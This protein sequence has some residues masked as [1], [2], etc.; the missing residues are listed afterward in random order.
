[1]YIEQRMNILQAIDDPLLFA[2]WFRNRASW[3]SWIVFLQALFALQVEDEA[4]FASCT[5][6]RPLPTRQSREAFLVVGRRGGKS[7]ICALIGVYLACFRI[8]RLSPGEKGI[9]MLLAAD[10]RQARVLI[11]YVKAFLEGVPMLRAM[12][13]NETA[14]AISL[15]NQVAIEIHTA[16]FR[17]VRG[18]TICAAIC[19]EI[20]Y[21]RSDESAN[22]DSEILNA[23]RPA[24]ATIPNSMLLCLSTPYSR[25]GALWD[26]HRKHFGKA[27]DVLVWQ[28]PTLT[29]NSSVPAS[30]I[31]DALEEDPASAS[32]EYLAQFRSDL[33]AFVSQE[34]VDACTVPSRFELPPVSGVRYIAFVDPAG[35]SGTDSMT[36]AIGHH[37]GAHAVLDLLRSRKPPFS[38]EAV[39]SEFA[40]TLKNYGVH[41]VHGD[42]YAGSWPSEQFQKHFIRYIASEETKSGIYQAMLPMLNSG[43]VELLDSKTLRQELI[44]LERKTARGG[45]D[46]IDHGPGR[47]DDVIN[48]AAGALIRC[49]HSEPL[50]A[51][52]FAQGTFSYFGKRSEGS[53]ASSGGGYH[54]ETFEAWTR[55]REGGR[56]LW[57]QRPR[58]DKE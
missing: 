40:A 42:K 41:T 14:D 53:F 7:F 21:W 23:L 50:G 28:A 52:M 49:V 29:M 32:A 15:T 26:A 18:Y 47:H 38:P 22:P 58:E 27:G 20:A 33:E 5:G 11:R 30:I 35:G 2:D 25:R 8:Y 17:S 9:C 12:I 44:G 37:E 36:L 3:T 56:T 46:S 48:S 31:N 43:R 16:S 24:M 57:G 4:L 45:R 51:D 39:V 34:V 6:N 55:A 13:E 1:L 19:D 10:R 54:T